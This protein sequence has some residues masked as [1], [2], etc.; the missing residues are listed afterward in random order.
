MEKTQA[1]EGSGPA[2]RPAYVSVNEWIRLSGLSRTKTYDLLGRGS[3]RAI[4][5]GR[6]TLI[7]VETSLD[8]LNRQPQW[9][10]LH[11]GERDCEI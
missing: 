9:T 10:S 4:R 1:N 2:S 3:L 8:W 11:S 6:R 7:D 5:I